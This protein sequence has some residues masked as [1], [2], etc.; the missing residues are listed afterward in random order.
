ML[1]QIGGANLGP[2]LRKFWVERKVRSFA[3]QASSKIGKN[4]RTIIIVQIIAYN[5]EQSIYW[6]C[7]SKLNLHAN[8]HCGLLVFESN[9]GQKMTFKSALNERKISELNIS[10]HSKMQ[11]APV[12][13]WSNFLHKEAYP[14]H[15]SATISTTKFVYI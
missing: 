1:T 13:F 8:M 5:F 9:R 10:T 12:W 15:S 4:S 3:L 2:V 14:F 6:Y 7:F 11:L